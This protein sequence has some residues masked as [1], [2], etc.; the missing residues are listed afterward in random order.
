M[1]EGRCIEFEIIK[2]SWNKYQL[3]DNSVLKTRI[4]LKSVR[5]TTKE[6]AAQYLVDTQTFTIVY[7]DPTLRGNANPNRVSNHEILSSM[8]VEDMH[9][10]GLAQDSNEYKLDDGTKIK[11]HNN[12]ASISRS[13]LKDRHGDPIYS[14]VS[15]NQ[16]LF[17]PPVL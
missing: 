12:I 9:Y 8:E 6:N 17:R 2:E 13:S 14:V 7:A 16:M 15:S 10:D 3:Q 5:R 1:E 11:I 4:V